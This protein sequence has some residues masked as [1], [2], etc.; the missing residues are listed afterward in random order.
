MGSN[1]IMGQK[2]S[3]HAENHLYDRMD[4]LIRHQGTTC[5]GIVIEDNC[6]IGSNVTILDGA[7]IAT[8]CVIGAGSIV[9]GYI[10]PNSIAV[11]A[12]ARVIR[13]RGSPK[14]LKLDVE[15]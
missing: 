11:G 15:H 7:H 4:L 14:Q 8:G 3:F 5:Q 2:V 6:W 1:V 13:G 12:P 9:K 10:P